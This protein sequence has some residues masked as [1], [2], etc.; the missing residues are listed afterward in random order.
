MRNKKKNF[1]FYLLDPRKRPVL[2]LFP[3]KQELL[4]GLQMLKKFL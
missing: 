2:L 3:R 1:S 4:E